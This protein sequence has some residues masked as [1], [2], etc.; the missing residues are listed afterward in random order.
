MVQQLGNKWRNFWHRVNAL[1]LAMDAD[2]LEDIHR[3]LRRLETAHRQLEASRRR[4]ARS[5][6]T[7]EAT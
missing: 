2:P 3:R 1:F 7:D 4:T 5:G 6:A